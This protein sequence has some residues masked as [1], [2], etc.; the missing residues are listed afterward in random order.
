MKPSVEWGRGLGEKELE[1]E[2]E[3]ARELQGESAAA[4]PGPTVSGS[5][6]CS[7]K[8]E[9]SSI[10][11][12]ELATLR[13]CHGGAG[14]AEGDGAGPAGDSNPASSGRGTREPVHT[15]PPCPRPL[16]GPQAHRRDP[17]LARE[18]PV[19]PKGAL[20]GAA[21]PGAARE[22]LACY[23]AVPSPHAATLQGGCMP[24]SDARCT[25]RASR[26]RVIALQSLWPRES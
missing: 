8:A 10:Q 13:P 14:G 5:C 21:R 11:S 22:G 24:D 4:R 17:V 7:R 20:T 23:N 1:Q 19:S 6:C 25:E 2:L 26:E 16:W 3:K 12:L 18:S 9:N 15:H